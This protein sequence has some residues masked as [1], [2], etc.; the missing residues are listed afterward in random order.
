MPTNGA[1]MED[2]EDEA[3]KAGRH[4]DQEKGVARLQALADN[5]APVMQAQIVVTSKLLESWV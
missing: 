3:A 2:V 1:A 5:E 4:N